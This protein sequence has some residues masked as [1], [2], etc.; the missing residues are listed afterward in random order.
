MPNAVELIRED[1]QRLQRLFQEFEEAGEGRERQEISATALRELE[2]HAD[3]EE[4]IFYPALREEM[5]DEEKIDEAE[6]EHHVARLLMAELKKMNRQN[7]RYSAKFKVLAE[8]VKHHIEE[9]EANVLPEAEHILDGTVLGEEMAERKQELQKKGS[10]SRQ[11]RARHGGRARQ[12][13][14]STRGKGTRRRSA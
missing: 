12:V 2:I 13:R 9:E 14:K 6:E 3:L 7:Q 10:R 4:E 5:E 1:H 11:T 8:S